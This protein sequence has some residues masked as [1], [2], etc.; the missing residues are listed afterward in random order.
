MLIKEAKWISDTILSLPVSKESLVLNFGSQSIKYNYENRHILELV[1]TPLKN[2]CDLKNLDIQTGPGI[3]YSGDLYDDSFFNQLKSTRFDAVLLCNV[4]EHVK[5]INLMSKRISELIKPGGFLIF[6]GPFKYPVHYDP[7]DN[8]FRP[9]VAEVVGLFDGY[10][11]LKGEIITD[12]TYSF[13][14]F[15]SLKVLTFTFLRILTPFYRYKKWRHVVLPKFRWWNRKFK[16][17]CVL[18]KKLIK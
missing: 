17:T 11:T 8:G 1:I 10:E 15:R 16:V 4:L 2:K 14:L 18:M 5:N 9:E 3:D 6:T 7:I 12:Y 13:Y